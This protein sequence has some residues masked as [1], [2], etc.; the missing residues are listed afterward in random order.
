[1]YRL[2]KSFEALAYIGLII[3]SIS[4][5]HLLSIWSHISYIRDFPL[6]GRFA[7]ISHPVVI[8][9]ISYIASGS[10]LAQATLD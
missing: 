4:L 7:S 10:P 1:M 5:P 3:L 8:A 2:A 6:G 9:L